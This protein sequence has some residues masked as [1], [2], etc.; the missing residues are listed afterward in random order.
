MQVVAATNVPFVDVLAVRIAV[1]RK[2]PIQSRPF[3]DG[4]I[5]SRINGRG[6]GAVVPGET[7][8]RRLHILKNL[9][10][11]VGIDR[12]A[13]EIEADAIAAVVRDA[14]QLVVLAAVAERVDR[15]AGKPPQYGDV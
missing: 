15:L 5:G 10:K 7:E 3:V 1:S 2:H 11:Q 6:Q 14:G 12:T 4:E 8:G 13:G 9:V